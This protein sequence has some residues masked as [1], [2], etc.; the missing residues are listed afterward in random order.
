M[1]GVINIVVLNGRSTGHLLVAPPYP[2]LIFFHSIL[3]P[4]RLTSVDYIS[5]IQASS[6]VW[7]MGNTGDRRARGK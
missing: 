1:E 4:R 6:R 3:C 5:C 7:Q 2:P